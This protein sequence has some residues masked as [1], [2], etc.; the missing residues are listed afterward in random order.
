MDWLARYPIGETEHRSVFVMHKTTFQSTH[1]GFRARREGWATVTRAGSVQGPLLVP[2]L[3]QDTVVSVWDMPASA[4]CVTGW[5][6]EVGWFEVLMGERGAVNV[7]TGE[8]HPQVLDP[9]P[10]IVA[11]AIT[12][13]GHSVNHANALHG[14][15]DKQDAVNVF[16]ALRD[17]GEQ[18]DTNLLWAWALGHG[19]TGEEVPQLVSFSD[20]ALQRS[21]RF[22][23]EPS[24]AQNMSRLERWRSAA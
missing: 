18:W 17:S 1:V 14:S 19:F 23:G 2:W 11:A 21:H 15:M 6:D 22:R 7:I 8:T 10:P 13:L 12:E 16:A 24:R 20:R 9:I 3:R 4:F 5:G